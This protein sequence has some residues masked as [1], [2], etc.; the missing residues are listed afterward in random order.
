MDQRPKPKSKNYKTLRRRHRGKF[1]NIGFGHDF[2]DMTPKAQAT[3]KIGKLDCIKI[4]NCTSK[5]KI[6][7]LK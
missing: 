3:T 4:K 1:Y 2:F 6:N 7:R 5:D